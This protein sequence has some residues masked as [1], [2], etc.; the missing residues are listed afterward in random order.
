[1]KKVVLIWLD[2]FSDRYLSS[3][4]CPFLW[5]LSKSCF[6]SKISP[7]FAYIGIKYC[8]ELG[9]PI[10]AHKVWNDHVF[11]GFHIGN[12]LRHALFRGMLRFVD[13]VSFSDGLNKILRYALF[14]VSKVEYGTP[15]LIPASLIDFFPV[16]KKSC[17][18]KDLYEML[19]EHG[20]KYLR[21]EPKLNRGESAII[22]SIPKLLETYDAL[23]FKLNSLDR[24]G[25][26][27][28]PLS[29]AVK[30]RVSFFDDL[31]KELVGA[32]DK[33]V[34][35]I[36]MSDHG[37]VP[38]MRSFDITSFLD[39]K[40]FEY[41]RH[42]ISFVG[43]TYVSFWFRDEKYRDAIVEELD[44]LEVGRFLTFDDKVRL[45]LDNIGK[46]YG[47]E[48]F[49]SEEHNVFFPEFYHMRKPP[50]GIHGYAFGKYDMPIFLTYGDVPISLKKDK[51]DF[52]DI[53]PTV[54]RLLD[55]PIP[56][57]VEAKSLV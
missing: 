51:I 50:K 30:Q 32:L 34:V 54:L 43:A 23:F 26:E 9:I 28:G 53:M 11:T 40:G 48:I 18:R 39:R 37:M 7:L 10:N 2:A 8:F 22:R 36:V 56:S 35:L 42:Y 27:Y 41:G 13:Q 25:H 1:M 57:S 17:E 49:V 4:S 29:D 31:L 47:E 45:G 24:L 44:K 46:E 14:K 3:E 33:N 52:I 15:H 12:D 21:K 5:D 55:L 38:I 16:P 6:F 20:V 19:R